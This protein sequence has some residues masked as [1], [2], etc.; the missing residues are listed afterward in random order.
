M[1]R[2]EEDRQIFVTA[3]HSGQKHHIWTLTENHMNV[4]LSMNSMLNENMRK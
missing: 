2:R 3:Q 4:D 1:G